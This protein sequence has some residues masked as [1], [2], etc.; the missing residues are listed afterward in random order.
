MSSLY[1]YVPAELKLLQTKEKNFAGT[2]KYKQDLGEG[3]R[4][5]GR[6]TTDR[7]TGRPTRHRTEGEGGIDEYIRAT[8]ASPEPW[9][10]LRKSCRFQN[11]N[12]MQ[13]KNKKKEIQTKYK[14]KTKY[15]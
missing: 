11:A 10:Q 15:K 6:A 4:P 7:P 9:A 3:G 14:K 12:K 1:F 8:A 13:K 5:T 2:N